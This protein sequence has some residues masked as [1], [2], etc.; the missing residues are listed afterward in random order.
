VANDLDE[1]R[2]ESGIKIQ[3]QNHAYQSYAQASSVKA[4]ASRPAIPAV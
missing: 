1:K 3:G 2:K 4:V